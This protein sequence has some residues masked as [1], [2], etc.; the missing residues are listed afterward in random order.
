MQNDKETPGN[1]ENHQQ[2]DKRHARDDERDNNYRTTVPSKQEFQDMK[3]LATP[4][5][6]RQKDFVESP[7]EI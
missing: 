1:K 7:Q 6:K 2:G 3:T 5:R 4:T